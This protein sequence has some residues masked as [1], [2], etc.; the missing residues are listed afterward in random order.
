M[1]AIREGIYIRKLSE[2]DGPFSLGHVYS[3]VHRTPEWKQEHFFTDFSE[4]VQFIQ[5]TLRA[6]E[7]GGGKHGYIP[8]K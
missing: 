7:K 6:G 2:R 4:L 8:A 3:A 5:A 1:Q